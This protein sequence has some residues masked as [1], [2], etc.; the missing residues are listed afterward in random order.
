MKMKAVKKAKE[1]EV[2]KSV[3]K[4]FI[5]ASEECLP[6]HRARSSVISSSSFLQTPR[7]SLTSRE[8]F[9]F[10]PPSLIDSERRK[11]LALVE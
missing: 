6:K 4:K 10:P 1:R 5:D 11:T 3:N 9:E 7:L 2:E 8:C